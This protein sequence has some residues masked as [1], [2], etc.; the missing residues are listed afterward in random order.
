MNVKSRN[1]D[2]C[3][4]QPLQAVVSDPNDFRFDYILEFWEMC[5]KMGG[6]LGKRKRQLSKDTTACIHQTCCGVVDLAKH[7]L[8]DEG[9]DYVCLGDFTTDPLEKAFSKFCQG[10]G[11]AYFINVQQVTEKFRIQKAKLQITSNNALIS[12][13]EPSDHRCENC[14]CPKQ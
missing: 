10:S 5:L 2:L 9:N 7:L 3:K 14:D 1:I 11:G 13:S 12:S 6:Q 4:R 8:S